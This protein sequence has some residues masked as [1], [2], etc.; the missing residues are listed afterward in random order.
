MQDDVNAQEL[1]AL[2]A[3]IRCVEEYKLEADY[4]LDPLQKRVAQ[5]ERSQADKK[6][7]GGEYGKRQQTKKQKANG[8]FQG[9]RRT[10]S[11]SPATG[12][13]G[14]PFYKERAVH[15]ELP[16]RYPRAYWPACDYRVPSQAAHGRQANDQRSYNYPHD[17]KFTPTSY[18]AA[19]AN[20][21][22]Y[23]GSGL[24]PSNQSYL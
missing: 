12:R 3:V 19:P 15:T 4:P 21:G 20:Y 24:Q 17:D 7:K 10:P 5:L 1:A 8:R 18:N 22:S 6:K 11:F 16:E 9:H 23:A 2:K 14:P 13:Q